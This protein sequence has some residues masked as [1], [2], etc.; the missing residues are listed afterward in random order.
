M[1]FVADFKRAELTSCKR[2]CM[3]GR[4]EKIYNLAI[5]RKSLSTFDLSSQAAAVPYTILLVVSSIWRSYTEPT[6][7]STVSDV[8]I[9]CKKTSAVVCNVHIPLQVWVAFSLMCWHARCSKYLVSDI[10]QCILRL[11]EQSVLT[12]GTSLVVQCL[13]ICLPTIPDLGRFHMPLGN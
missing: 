13:R 9:L 6:M 3:A 4:T 2:C 7:S 1:L 8:H 5:S 10:S 11:C 12:R